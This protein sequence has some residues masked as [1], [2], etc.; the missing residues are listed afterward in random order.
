MGRSLFAC[1]STRNQ[2][3][4]TVHAGYIRPITAATMPTSWLAVSSSAADVMRGTTP[5][6]SHRKTAGYRRFSV[7][8]RR[9]TVGSQRLTVGFR[10]YTVRNP[11]VMR[12]HPT[13]NRRNPTVR[14]SNSQADGQTVRQT[15]ET[16][17]QVRQSQEI[18]SRRPI[19]TG[20]QAGNQTGN[21]TERRL[22]WPPYACV[23]VSGTSGFNIGWMLRYS[24]NG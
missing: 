11:T 20:F 17:R 10:T 7:G 12:R 6:S 8:Y 18:G 14:R 4:I 24:I 16:V 22:T 1:H 15:R 23:P 21:R 9:I 19:G 2:S 3:P 13:V 5:A